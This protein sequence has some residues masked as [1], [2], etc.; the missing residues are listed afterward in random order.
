MVVYFVFPLSSRPMTV[1]LVSHFVG[2]NRQGRLAPRG[3]AGMAS[4][5]PSAES[6]LEVEAIAPTTVALTAPRHDDSIALDRLSSGTWVATHLL[7]REKC[8]LGEEGVWEL[9]V[10][11]EGVGAFYKVDMASGHIDCKLVEDCF[12]KLV[13]ISERGDYYSVERRSVV[14]HKTYVRVLVRLSKH[15]VYSER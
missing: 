7:T 8:A 11:D 5:A 6:S 1:F 14:K 2:T 10:N 15:S 12:S 13:L 9:V 4:A 3:K